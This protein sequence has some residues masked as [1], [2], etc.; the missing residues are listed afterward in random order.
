[1]LSAINDIG[2]LANRFS[3]GTFLENLA[4]ELPDEIRGKKQHV[5]LLDFS[6]EKPDLQIKF[7]EVTPGLTE[8]EYLWIGNADGNN[9][10]QWYLT[11]NNLAFILSQ[12]LPNIINIM[13]EDTSLHQKAKRALK[14]C[15]FDTGVTAGAE[16]RYRYVFNPELLSE[17]EGDKL[18]DILALPKKP[19][20]K[21]GVLEKNIQRWIKQRY[22]ISDQ[23]ICLYVVLLDGVAGA[24]FPEYMQ[25]VEEIK[26]GE[27]FE[28]ERGICTVC[29][30]E[31]LITGNTSRMKFK[32]YI[33]DKIGFA[34]NL[35]KEAFYRHNSFC[36]ECY[37]SALLAESFIRNNFSSRLGHLNLYIIPG[38]LNLPLSNLN[39]KRFHNW[40]KYVPESINALKG[41][42]SINE[43]EERIQDYLKKQEFDNELVFNLLFYQRNKA[44]LKVLKMV[45]DVPPTR[46]REIALA[47]LNVNMASNE[48]FPAIGSQLALDLNRMY[49]LIPLQQGQNKQEYQKFLAF[50]EAVFDSRRISPA[51]LVKQ[52]LELFKI[53]AF[54]KRNFNVNPGDAKYGDVELAKAGLKV[55]YLN[56]FLKK[57]GV[58][59]MT[60]PIHVE[61]LRQEED[62]FIKTMGYNSQQ[63]SLFI[64]GYLVAEVANAQYNSNLNSKPVLNKVAYQGMSIRRVVALAN[65]VF[66]KLRQYKKLNVSNEKVL[67]VMRQ[68]MDREMGNWSLSD[69][70]N[71]FYLLSGYS[72]LTGKVLNAAK[73]KGK[74]GA[75]EDE[76]VNKEQQ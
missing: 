20:K 26:V 40:V 76:R 29:G 42:S 73:Q 56:C 53:Y 54:N 24:R 69:K 28:K 74:G 41:L 22:S 62:Q 6:T 2:I 67:A 18:A 49:Y 59:E 12:T 9:S 17:Y 10:P 50:I 27:I 60:D 21:V 13:P 1:M 16:Q 43:M 47:F 31:G 35:N 52:Y 39:S 37:Q 66:D 23:E 63:A 55:S 45:K 15:F 71:V 34:N 25:K 8:K 11:T 30:N 19:I 61:G 64:L 51:F 68:L 72:Y 33:T 65:E 7:A 36:R 32:Y 46:F 44:E 3:Q 4:N 48:A 57:V 75:N 5:V 14:N 58:I 38:F 70:E